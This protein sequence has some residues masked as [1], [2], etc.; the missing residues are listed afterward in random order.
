MKKSAGYRVFYIFNIIFFALV[1][2]SVIIPFANVLCLSLEP[3]Y[4]AIETGVL[5][6]IPRNITL[7]AYKYVLRDNLF[8]RA[9]LNSVVITAAGAIGGVIV[10]AMLGYS[11][12]FENVK[13]H[14]I[15]SFLVLFTMM[16]NGGIIPTY[17]LVKKLGLLDTLWS[18]FIPVLISGY[19]VILMRSFFQSIPVSLAESAFLDGASEVSV[20]FR[21]IVPL[22]KPIF[23]T[24][25]LFYAVSRWND[26][27]NGIMFIT[28]LSKKPLQVLLREILLQASADADS[29][30]D[31]VY[32]GVNVKMAIVFITIIPTML[33][34]P[35]LQKYF[36]K[37]IMLGA[38]KG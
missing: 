17:I 24:I 16:F 33:F 2:L 21:I 8:T 25:T 10:T 31:T 34:Y 11:L 26:F 23:A 9:F 15:V 18:L 7:E 36:T 13:G 35:F 4:I 29:G 37:G 19:N 3:N 30:P 14:K 6:L 12:T 32:I 1:S 38:V 5:H 28:T 20:F 27:F 22:S